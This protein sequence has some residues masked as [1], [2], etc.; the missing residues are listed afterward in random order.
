MVWQETP[1]TA[2]ILII[3][4]VSLVAG[5]YLLAFVNTRSAKI[6]GVITLLGAWWLLT[7][8][9]EIAGG[10]LPTKVFWNTLEY[11]GAATLP[12]AWL[13]LTLVNLGHL[14]WLQPRRLLLLSIVP[15]L[16]IVAAFTNDVHRLFWPSHELTV[17]DSILV[18]SH[19]HGIAYWIF[20]LYVGA[21]ILGAFFMLLRAV[22]N[23]RQLY[24]RQA[25]LMMVGVSVITMG[26]IIDAINKFVVSPVP[27]SWIISGLLIVW[28]TT[29]LRIG[30]IIP[31]ATHLVL[32]SIQDGVIVA[33]MQGRLL[34]LNP[35]AQRLIG[36]HDSQAEI[37]GKALAQLWP[38]GVSLLAAESEA[39]GAYPIEIKTD[40]GDE[41][42][43]YEVSRSIIRDVREQPIGY[44]LVL[45]DSTKRK[46]AERRT[47]ELSL[48]RER[49]RLLSNFIRDVS[50]EFRTPLAT[51]SLSAHL[52]EKRTK[53]EDR[54]E[55]VS[56]IQNQVNN[57]TA[58]IDSL[59]TM[60]RLDSGTP[61]A[62]DEV[63]LNTAVA[64]AR[65][66]MEADIA[67]KAVTVALELDP[68]RMHVYGSPDDLA[69]AVGNILHNAIRYTPAHGQITVHTYHRSD[70]EVIVEIRDTGEGISAKHLP[71]IF[72]RFYRADDA[73]SSTGFGLG[74]SIAQKIVELHGGSIEVESE[75]GQGSTFRIVLPALR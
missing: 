5:F 34:N 52:L 29:Y 28:G 25:L 4:G 24:R 62:R 69:L 13:L 38:A 49:I 42:L 22:I 19:P 54:G 18:L 35:V 8:A 72:N 43:Q 59:V 45:R 53:P 21:A 1:Y 14:E 12:S 57:I 75:A 30:E 26:A 44:V 47:I 20:T 9:L 3:G 10:D 46:E 33:D 2:Y 40:H 64:N 36:G 65:T 7:L 73:H 71:Y 32:D 70:N 51:I 61:A 17:A 56:R 16:T 63:D 39:N 68:E 50:H 48:E 6:G 74:L 11:L 23:Y 27:L 60:S 15:A 66:R 31:V 37:I 58:L 41:A 55:Q 67:A